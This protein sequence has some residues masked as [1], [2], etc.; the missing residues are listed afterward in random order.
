MGN[1]VFPEKPDETRLP[2][3]NE[4]EP[5]EIPDVS[6]PLGN[7][8]FS[9]HDDSNPGTGTSAKDFMTWFGMTLIF[10]TGTLAV[11]PVRKQKSNKP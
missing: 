5:E 3:E 10:G 2:D 11:K 1:T 7:M 9:V 6:P 8:E 4:S